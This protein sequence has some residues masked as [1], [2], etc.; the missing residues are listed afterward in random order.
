[1]YI[2]SSNVMS[3]VL[4]YLINSEPFF[5]QNIPSTNITLKF[6]SYSIISVMYLWNHSGY[7][8]SSPLL[9]RICSFFPPILAPE[10]TQLPD[11]KDLHHLS[12][13][14]GYGAHLLHGF[15]PHFLHP[16]NPAVST[17]SGTSP[18]SGGGAFVKPFPSNLPLPSAFAPPK[19]LG[20]GID[21]VSVRSAAAMPS[22]PPGAGTRARSGHTDPPLNDHRTFS[23]RVYCS[24]RPL[25]LEN[26][27]K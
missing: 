10:S 8:Q 12:L 2:Q 14:S 17:A 1:M 26:Y 25:V 19:C 4:T 23:P 24:V 6:Y 5:F 27:F 16:L 15:Q 21:Q 13:M 7:K 3:N 9:T 22:V 11:A 18:F 20:F